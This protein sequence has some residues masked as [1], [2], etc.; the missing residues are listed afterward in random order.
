MCDNRWRKDFPI[1][2]TIIYGSPLVYLDNAATSQIPERVIERIA[3]H[4]REE[5]GNIHRGIHY[6]S[7][8]STA[9]VEEAR[10]IIAEFIGAESPDTVVFTSGTTD[11]I[12]LA[13]S[14]F[15]SSV[16]A[17]DAIMVTELEHH[18]NYVPW[19]QLCKKTGAAFLVCPANDGELDL[20][21][22]ESLLRSYHVCLVA[23]TQVSNL[24]G[25][26]T[27]LS[28]IISLAHRYGTEV[29]VDGAQGILHVGAN[30]SAEDPDYYAFSGHKMLGP[31]GVGVLY[32]KKELLERLEPVRYGGGMVDIV[33][34]K[35]TTWGRLPHRLEAGTPN[36]SGVIGLGEAVRYLLE[37]GLN[38]MRVCERE[39]LSYTI[40]RLS[41]I[42]RVHIL[43]NPEKREALVSFIVDGAHPYDLAALLD[44]KGIAVRSGHLCAQPALRSLNAQSAV[45]VSPA[46]YNTKSEIDRFCENLSMLIKMLAG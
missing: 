8:R 45:R 44:K 2:D 28:K 41:A 35:E 16:S 25:T 11:S 31:T 6:L 30:V 1:L 37:N 21:M 24:T 43:G 27:P 42:E 46:F 32:G 10:R 9:S 39:L 29:L 20:D 33:E 7:E 18:S 19:Q 5:H 12:N 17:D 13:A 22:M 40:E 3:A 36:I 4:Y 23:V 34:E 38:D 14:G 26:R 15:A